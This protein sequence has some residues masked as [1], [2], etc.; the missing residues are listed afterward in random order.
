MAQST[1]RDAPTNWKDMTDDQ[2][3]DCVTKTLTSAVNS[4]AVRKALLNPETAKGAMAAAGNVTFDP[5]AVVSAYPDKA[6]AA[7]EIAL[8]LPADGEEV[9]AAKQ[10]LCTYIKY[11]KARGDKR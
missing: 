11:S 7:K 2:Q 5:D 10:W 6:T 9:D 4:E 8:R 1:K 3:I